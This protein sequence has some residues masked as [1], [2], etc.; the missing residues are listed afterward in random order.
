MFRDSAQSDIPNDGGDSDEN[1]DDDADSKDVS[2]PQSVDNES[3]LD[4]EEEEDFPGQ[5]I[6]ESEKET[7][8]ETQEKD[9]QTNLNTG[10]FNHVPYSY[11]QQYCKG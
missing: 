1:D 6:D 7:P 5:T 11:I 4:V 10:D 9:P 3:F 8:K 2:R